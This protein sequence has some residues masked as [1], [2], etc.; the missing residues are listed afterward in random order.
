MSLM[1]TKMTN[2]GTNH[3][4]TGL[5]IRAISGPWPPDFV[6]APRSHLHIFFKANMYLV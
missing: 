1:V 4:M 3:G 5:C 6:W 2:V